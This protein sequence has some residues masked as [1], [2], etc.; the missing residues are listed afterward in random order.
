MNDKV[1]LQIEK[2][3]EA[4]NVTINDINNLINHL[5]NK[6]LKYM[7]QNEIVRYMD[8]NSLPDNYKV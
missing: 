5:Q 2:I 8:N 3:L 4:N 1:I 6:Y 7:I